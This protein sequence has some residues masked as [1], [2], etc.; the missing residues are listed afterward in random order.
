MPQIS[1]LKQN[2]N[3]AK[4]NNQSLSKAPPIQKKQSSWDSDFYSKKDIELWLTGDAN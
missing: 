1:N 2:E 4:L 3:Q